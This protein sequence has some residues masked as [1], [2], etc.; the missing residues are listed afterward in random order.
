MAIIDS[1]SRDLVPREDMVTLQKNKR[2]MLLLPST[3]T[4]TKTNNQKGSSNRFK[5]MILETPFDARLSALLLLPLLHVPHA[6]ISMVFDNM[7]Y[8]NN[9]HSSNTSSLGGMV[10]WA[11]IFAITNL[12]MDKAV[13]I[14]SPIKK[15]TSKDSIFTPLDRQEKNNGNKSLPGTFTLDRQQQLKYNNRKRPSSSCSSSKRLLHKRRGSKQQLYFQQQ[16]DL[17]TQKV[18]TLQSQ[19]NACMHN[20]YPTTRNLLER[21]SIL[22]RRNSL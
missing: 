15:S 21:K 6:L 17:L 22:L 5:S 14:N 13:F 8:A 19:H 1:L 10:A 7:S 2:P 9:D 18:I 20:N 11:F 3:I 16:E 12:V 4:K